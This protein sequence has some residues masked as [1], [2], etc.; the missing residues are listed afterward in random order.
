MGRKRTVPPRSVVLHVLSLHFPHGPADAVPAVGARSAFKRLG[1]TVPR[2]FLV[3]RS[4][5]ATSDEGRIVAIPDGAPLS[6]GHSRWML[7]AGLC[8]V[9]RVI[10]R[11]P[12][13]I[14]IAAPLTTQSE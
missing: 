13:S 1:I 6:G 2:M 7:I 9:C 4:F 14:R 3:R 8:D 5:F 10:E 11:T 12:T